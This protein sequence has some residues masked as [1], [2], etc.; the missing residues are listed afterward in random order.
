MPAGEY[1][2]SNVVGTKAL[3][4]GTREG[5]VQAYAGSALLR[6]DEGYP[7]T[8]ELL[9][10]RYGSQYFLSEVWSSNT[11]VG[12]ELLKSGAERELTKSSAVKPERVIVLAQGPSARKTVAR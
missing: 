9:F 6:A 12:R 8:S 5:G 3:A 7:D 4:I 11:S 1:T 10:K 2:I